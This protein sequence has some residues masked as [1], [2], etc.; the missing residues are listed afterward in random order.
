MHKGVIIIKHADQLVP[1]AAFEEA[2]KTCKSC[3]GASMAAEG[4]LV[5][6]AVGKAGTLEE[7]MQTQT[8]NKDL[9]VIFYFGD[10]PADYQRED[11]QPFVLLRDTEAKP[12][13]ACFLEGDFKHHVPDKSLHSGE[14]SVVTD[15]LIPKLKTYFEMVD[16]NIDKLMETLEKPAI[17]KEL[18]NTFSDRG[19]IVFM[20]NTRK[21]IT[22]SENALE[23]TFPW[24]SMSQ[25]GD[26]KE[27]ADA[28]EESQPEGLSNF[29]R[30]GK[31]V[32]KSSTPAAADV[33]A[34]PTGKAPKREQAVEVTKPDEKTVEGKPE[35]V[36]EPGK[37]DTTAP[38]VV[39]PK[40]KCPENVQGKNAI[41]AWYHKNAGFCP[42]GYKHKPTVTSKLTAEP[43]KAVPDTAMAAALAKAAPEAGSGKSVGAGKETTSK[44]TGKDTTPK[45]V[46]SVTATGGTPA[47]AKAP[48]EPVPV[49]SADQKKYI[50]DDFLKGAQV[51][52]S[53][54]VNARDIID[55]K[56]MSD[57]SKY[58]M[59]TEQV[60]LTGLEQTF[61]W[62]Y[63]SLVEMGTY[64]PEALA[65]LFLETRLA[66]LKV[67]SAEGKAVTE[68][69]VQEQ[70]TKPAGKPIRRNG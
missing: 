25:V 39:G 43:A 21:I 55:P 31:A 64:A 33:S 66:Y 67:L 68:N 36:V 45:H 48:S 20:S 26:Y 63:G 50:V 18:S 30:P 51:Q 49:L 65:C 15:T 44:P 14:Y 52:K 56:L 34:K 17:G 5:V 7:L 28:K 8:D 60:G 38:D 58:P 40:V 9:G 27:G 3:Y 19:V 12:I 13:L 6:G 32:G 62:D 53:L 29:R 41:R 70:T 4:Q 61:R 37:T 23:G 42:D 59:F 46:A 22:Y 11:M 47:A 24:G 69:V 54:D 35:P 10:Y 16:N 2:L 57:D 1:Q